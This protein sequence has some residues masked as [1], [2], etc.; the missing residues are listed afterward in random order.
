M[1]CFCEPV[2]INIYPVEDKLNMFIDIFMI[3]KC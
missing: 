3:L 1:K 2:W